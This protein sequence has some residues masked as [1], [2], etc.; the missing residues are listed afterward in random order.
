ML[1]EPPPTAFDV[2]FRLFGFPVRV[3]PMFWVTTVLLGPT[4]ISGPLGAAPLFIWV[5]CVFASILLHE[6]GHAWMFRFYG[7]H[8]RISLHWLGGLASADR[9]PYRHWPN[10]WVSLAGPAMN[11]A[12]CAAVWGTN[13][14]SGW[15]GRHEYLTIT[16]LI[17]FRVN[18]YWALVNLLPVWPLDGGQVCREICFMARARQPEE[19]SLKISI[20]TAV[21]FA[22]WGLVNMTGQGGGP[23]ASLPWWVPIPGPYGII[24][25]LILAYGSYE[26]LQSLRRYSYGGYSDDAGYPWQR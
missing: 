6:L 3:H 15:A 22:G 24:W 16:Y 1:C 25:F 5:G 4:N 10:V 17:L 20:G 19:L 23:A 8:S 7:C 11:F 21:A 12:I 13:E 9:R 18:L 2:N 14:A 26:A